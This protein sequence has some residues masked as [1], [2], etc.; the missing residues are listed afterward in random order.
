MDKQK[1][2][3]KNEII[4]YL[5]KQGS[6]EGLPSTIFGKKLHRTP[7]LESKLKIIIINQKTQ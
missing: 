1:A 4:L 3:K 7:V 6:G 5:D 2:Q